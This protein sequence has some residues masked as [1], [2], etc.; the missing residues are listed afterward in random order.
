MKFHFGKKSINKF[1]IFDINLDN[2]KQYTCSIYELMEKNLS[3]DELNILLKDNFFRQGEIGKFL[4]LNKSL[5]LID[6]LNEEE[7]KVIIHSAKRII[8]PEFN[9]NEDISNSIKIMSKI[10]MDQ[11]KILDKKKEGMIR[12]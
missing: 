11:K 1:E 6:K 7:N 8:E 12:Y 9:D 3:K 5:K 10:A 4:G 2:L